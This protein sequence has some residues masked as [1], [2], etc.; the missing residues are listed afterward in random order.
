MDIALER[1]PG[2]QFYNLQLTEIQKNVTIGFGSRIGS[3]SLLHEGAII[4][5]GC[6]IGSHCNICG[7]QIGDR[8]SIQTGCHITRGVII[9]DDVFIG[10]GVIT[11][12][13]QLTGEK[14]V[15]P[16]FCQGSKIG[17]GSIILPG[18]RIG[19]GSLV[20]AGSVVTRNVP[21]GAKV[22]G[23]PARVKV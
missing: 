9:E 16:Y 4:G 11:L 2:V 19:R 20:G 12:N 3:F 13:D 21:D 7:S 5:A 1:F 17:G 10:P 14:L 6:L 8:V 22:M 23:N 15:S 18:V